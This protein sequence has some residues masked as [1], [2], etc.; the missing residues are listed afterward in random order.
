MTLGGYGKVSL[1]SV[2]ENAG[3][4]F[5]VDSAKFLFPGSQ[6]CGNEFV[7]RLARLREPSH[8]RTPGKAPAQALPPVD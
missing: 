2:T 3:F 7:F 5:V 6:D 8:G 1:M 4:E